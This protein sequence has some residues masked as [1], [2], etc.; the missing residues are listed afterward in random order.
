MIEIY[1][2]GSCRGNGTENATGGWAAVVYEDGIIKSAVAG[3]VENTTNNICELK[4]ILWAVGYYGHRHPTIYT[5]SAYALNA[6]T[7]WRYDWKANGWRRKDGEIKN[8][9][10]IQAFDRF[11]E[12]GLTVDLQKVKGHAN[13]KGNILADKLATGQITV[14]EVMAN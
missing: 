2:D 12:M 8:L 7:K 6:L 11:E 5:D 14:T 4:A 13:C 3:T 10:Y 9:D 1:T